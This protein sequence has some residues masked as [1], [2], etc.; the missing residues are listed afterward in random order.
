MVFFKISQTPRIDHYDE[1]ISI[2]ED[3]LLYT[4]TAVKLAD[5][6]IY[7]AMFSSLMT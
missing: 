1:A 2:V 4:H 7:L 3:S 5:S 6:P